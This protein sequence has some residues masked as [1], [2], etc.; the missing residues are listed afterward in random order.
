[1]SK[2]VRHL[3]Y[4]DAIAAVTQAW[5]VETFGAHGE[6]KQLP[7]HL[8]NHSSNFVSQP[9]EHPDMPSLV[10]E[11]VRKLQAGL[12]LPPIVVK[13]RGKLYDVVDGRH[14]AKAYAA[15][16]RTYLPAVVLDRS[17]SRDTIEAI[18]IQANTLHGRSESKGHL[19]QQ[20]SRHLLGMEDAI[21]AAVVTGGP[22]FD[23]CVEREALRAGLEPQLLRNSIRE[24]RAV[25]QIGNPIPGLTKSHQRALY[26]LSPDAL[27]AALDAVEKHHLQANPTEKLVSAMLRHKRVDLQIAVARSWEPVAPTVSVPEVTKLRQALGL[28]QS[29]NLASVLPTLDAEQI[30]VLMGEVELVAD[31]LAEIDGTLREHAA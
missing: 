16:N 29:C 23:E 28:I 26:R 5:L 30:A 1:M 27:P 15:A 9:R 10:G 2:H 18:S 19:R 31:Q 21:D 22:T 11:Y 13:Q 8:I 24:L 20:L 25:T 3:A 17:V 14:R 12:S 4:E 7:P 6:L